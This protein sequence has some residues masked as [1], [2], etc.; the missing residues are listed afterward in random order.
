MA[1]L[2]AF[3]EDVNTGRTA[4]T[5]LE[6]AILAGLGKAEEEAPDSGDMTIELEFD[7]QTRTIDPAERP[8]RPADVVLD[9]IEVIRPEK[10][11]P[12]RRANLYPLFRPTAVDAVPAPL[13]PREPSKQ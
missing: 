5:A 10:E 2:E 3:T 11:A 9:C 13:T 12:E 6:R 4:G 7:E 8:A 1:R